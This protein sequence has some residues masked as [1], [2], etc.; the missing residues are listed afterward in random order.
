MEICADHRLHSKLGEFGAVSIS[1]YSLHSRTPACT[2]VEHQLVHQGLAI[3]D[4]AK[5]DALL[6]SY[7]TSINL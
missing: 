3:E 2:P 1:W 5:S 4:G 7:L 6:R